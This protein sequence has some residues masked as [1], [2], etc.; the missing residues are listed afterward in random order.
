MS[1][2]WVEENIRPVSH[3]DLDRLL[4]QDLEPV[5]HALKQ[6]G[7]LSWHFLR[8][9]DGWK[10]SQNVRHVRLR[11]EVTDLN[12]LKKIRIFLKRRLDALQQNNVILDHYVGNHGMPVRKYQNYYKGESAGFDEQ[13]AHPKGWL[14]V[15]KYMEVG[16]EIALL[17]IKGRMNL[18]QLGPIYEFY[19]I[20]HLFPNQCRH[21]PFVP[22]I[23]N[24]PSSWIVYDVVNPSP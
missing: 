23:Q 6:K 5:V 2:Y 18:V 14:L 17:L 1:E 19:K 10:A 12:S 13:V 22:K 3:R 9:D 16:S 24:W 8:E 21:Y 15:K 7:I 11:I 4:I 20:S